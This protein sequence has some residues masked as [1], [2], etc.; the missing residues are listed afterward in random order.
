MHEKNN[1]ENLTKWSNSHPLIY[2]QVNDIAIGARGPRFDS[3]VGQI[4]ISAANESPPM[5]CFLAQALS[6]GDESRRSLQVS[7]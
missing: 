3:R 1:A 5:R 4:G 7:V 2:A 6:R